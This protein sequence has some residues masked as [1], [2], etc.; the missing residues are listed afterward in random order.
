MSLGP[1]PKIIDGRTV[2]DY[3]YLDNGFDA[4][5]WGPPQICP[6]GSYVHAFELRVSSFC[7][8]YHF[9]RFY[10]SIQH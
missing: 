6:V 9:P 4:G 5:D 10:I 3:L 7:Y 2:R 1:E 8:I